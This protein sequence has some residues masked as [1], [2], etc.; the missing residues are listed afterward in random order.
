MSLPG[1]LHWLATARRTRIDPRQARN[2]TTQFIGCM[3]GVLSMQFADRFPY[4]KMPL[5]R[6]LLIVLAFATAATV[7]AQQHHDYPSR[8]LRF[9]VANGAGS[10]PDIF[11]RMLGNRLT[12]QIGQQVVVDVRPGASGVLGTQLAKNAAPDGYTMVLASQTPFTTLPALTHDLPYDAEKDFVPLTRIASVNNTVAVH[13]GL[14]VSTMSDLI[15]LAK[16]R[17]AQLN[18]GSAGYGT[19]GHLSGALLNLLAGIDT[20]HVPYKGAAQT[21]TDVIAGQVQFM[22]SGPL[23]IMPHAK[24]GRVRAIATTGRSVDPIFPE[25]PVVADTVPGYEM[26]QWFG[27]AIPAKTPPAIIATL[28][29]A[30]VKALSA[31]SVKDVLA[32]QGATV[33]PESSAQFEA[34]MKADRLRLRKL[35][36]QTNIRLN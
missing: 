24:S 9:I 22:I 3:F 23:V 18:Y 10:S 17:P 36:T 32:S 15:K 25:L 14:G 30:I 28:H 20:V 13:N 7:H 6:R 5:A 35:G 1:T 33:Q 8:P 27:V 16:A 12:E 29:G 2:V 26:T 34:F 21:L 4:N 31:P 11:A 19:S